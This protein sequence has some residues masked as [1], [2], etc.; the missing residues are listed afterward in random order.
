MHDP[1]RVEERNVC[2]K[3]GET[4][5]TDLDCGQDTDVNQHSEG[6]DEVTRD[7]EREREG[8]S[9]LKEQRQVRRPHQYGVPA[10]PERYREPM[11]QVVVEDVV[12]CRAVPPERTRE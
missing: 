11:E 8:E 3:H 1:V 7:L 9:E 2:S 6:Q 5:R 10:W 12:Q 4:E